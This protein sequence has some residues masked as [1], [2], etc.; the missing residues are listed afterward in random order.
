M[1]RALTADQYREYRSQWT[2]IPIPRFPVKYYRELKEYNARLRVADRLYAWAKG[3]KYPSRKAPS[4]YYLRHEIV[5]AAYE[6]AYERLE[7][8]CGMYPGIVGLLDRSVFFN[9]DEYPAPDPM[10]APRQRGS[11]SQYA[12]QVDHWITIDPFEVNLHFL[13]DSLRKLDG[14][15][16]LPL[17]VRSAIAEDEYIGDDIPMADVDENYQP[18]WEDEFDF[19]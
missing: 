3:V 18:D 5:E 6:A 13:K 2:T 19:E 11:R 10:S 12:A 15:T 17:T 14:P 8:L 1:K 9:L 4:R 7:E 16:D